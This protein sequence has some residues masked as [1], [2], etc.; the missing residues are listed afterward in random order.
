MFIATAG[1]NATNAPEQFWSA[2]EPHAQIS[3]A[4]GVAVLSLVVTVL[5]NVASNVPTGID[6]FIN[7]KP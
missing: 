7:C 3:T 4:S 6:Y 5:S 1:F 2:V